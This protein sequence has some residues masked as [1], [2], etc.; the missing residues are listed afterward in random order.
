M[1]VLHVI[2]IKSQLLRF[3]CKATLS[4]GFGSAAAKATVARKAT[5]LRARLRRDSAQL[6]AENSAT[7]RGKKAPPFQT[8]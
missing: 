2:A 5:R 7:I 4:F 8:R 3:Q 6:D 1:I